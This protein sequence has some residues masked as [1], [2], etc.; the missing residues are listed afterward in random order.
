[1][2]LPTN[3]SSTFTAYTITDGEDFCEGSYP[4]PRTFKTKSEAADV[5]SRMCWHPKR[6]AGPFRVEPVTVV[7][8]MWGTTLS[9]ERLAA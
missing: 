4:L 5:M 9:V 7:R 2:T 1:M 8:S 6:F 3:L